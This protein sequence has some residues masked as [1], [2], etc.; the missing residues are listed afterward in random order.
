MIPPMRDPWDEAELAVDQKPK[1]P[2]E[3][4][5]RSKPV[6]AIRIP[7]GVMGMGEVEEL[8]QRTVVGLMELAESDTQVAKE[9]AEAK[10][11]WLRHLSR[12]THREA[13]SDR[14]S[15][16]YT[17]EAL[18]HESIDPETGENGN[19]LYHTYKVLDN[20]RESIGRSMRAYDSA[21]SAL[22]TISA[23]IRSVIA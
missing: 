10:A 11:A 7:Q 22:Q 1:R 2:T 4:T 23:N 17:S 15:A 14:K 18:A 3:R 16:Q 5:Q 21:V 20:M 12:V 8:L 9:A 13:N 6:D 19:D